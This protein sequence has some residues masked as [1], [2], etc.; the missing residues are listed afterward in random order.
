MCGIMAD[1]KSNLEPID[2]GDLNLKE[3]FVGGGEAPE[4]KKDSA[5]GAAPEAR[6]ESIHAVE[7]VAERKE[8]AVEKE[9]AYSKI[10]AKFAA[11]PRSTV[12]S[13]VEVKADATAV[14]QGMDAESKITN[15]VKIAEVKGIPHA[16]KVARH[17]EDNYT[18]DE[19]HD[20]LLGEELH[21]A[22]VKKGMIKEL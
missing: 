4:I 22:L 2:E 3:K 8:G 20:R 10:L 5:D 14:A 17:L 19:F 12:T 13:D 6:I 16:V 18:L 7:G 15:L 21:D 1:I 9:A 11:P